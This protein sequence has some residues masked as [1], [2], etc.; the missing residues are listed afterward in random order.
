MRIASVVG[1]LAVTAVV[2]VL[3]LPSRL[4]TAADDREVKALEQ[5]YQSEIRRLVQR[6]CHEC[7]SEKRTEA[8]IDFTAFATWADVRKHPQTW[9]KALAMLDSGQMPPKK[10]RQPADA[11]RT[12]L[13][14]WVSG[15]LTVEAKARAGDPGRVMLRR[16]S[17]AEYTYTLR[18]LTGIDSLDPAREFPGDGAAGE[19]FTNTG[20]ALVMSPALLTKYLDAAKE[21][22]SHAVL[23]PDGFRFSP[24]TTPRDWTEETLAQIREFYREFSDPRGGDKVNLQG[25][26][27][28]TNQGGRL[29]L[30]RYF[31]ATIG[32]R[33]SLMMGRKSIGTVARKHG[34]NAR[35]LGTLWQSL[36]SHE[37]SLL[38]DGLRSR[39]RAARPE[40]AA[41]LG[42]DVAAWQKG[43][44]R[45]TTVGHIGK[46]GGPKKWLEPVTPLI[47][48]QEM[49]FK[50]PPSSDGEQVTLS[51]VASD[52]GDGNEHDFV[53]WQQP[54][55]MAPGRPDLLLR[56]VR[57]V[58][59]DLAAR[60]K[61][62]FAAAARYL[63]AAALAAAAPGTADVEQLARKHGV[64][65]DAL[66]AWLDYLGIGSGGSVALGGHFTNK[67]KSASGYDFIKG[68]GRNETPML[69]AN[70]SDKGVRIPGNM[71]PHSV[72]VHPSP[73]LRA[74]VGWRSPVTATFRVDA[75]V[76][77]AHPECGNG[78]TWSLELRRGAT[79]QRLAS[80]IAQGSKEGKADR[81]ERLAIQTGDLVSLLIGP[82][83]GNH[84]CDLTAIELKLSSDGGRTWDLAADVSSDVLAGNPHADRFGNQG[85]W[86]FYTEPD[87]GGSETGPVIPAGS[88]LAKWQLAR[89]ADEKR[90]L[91][92]DVQKLLTAGPPVV[93]GNPDLALY[94]QL[95]SLGGPLFGTMPRVRGGETTENAPRAN[96]ERQDP[97]MD[98]A[99]WG[100][101]PGM[102]AKHPSG[103]AIDAASLC[104]QA[105][106]V[107]TV[108]LP[109]E[110]ASGC[111]LVT[112]GV[113][114]Q[115]AG[116]LGSVQLELVAGRPSRESGL[117]PSEA[118]VTVANGQWTA[119]NQ[120]TSYATPI[121]VNENS[122]TRK[123]IESAFDDFRRLFPAALCYT[124]IVPVDEV[125]TLTLYYREDDHLARLMLDQSQQS[126]LN[127]LWD[128]L[129]YISQDALTQVDAFAQLME[130]ATQDADPKVF[131]PMRK[132][133]NDRATAFRQHLIDTQP[134]H[135]DVLLDFA[136][137]A[138]RRPL[139]VAESQ[140]L[141]ALYSKMRKQGIPHD[142]AFRLVLARVLVAPAFLY[143]VEKP[144]PGAGQGPVSDWEL[145]SRLSY[146]LWSTQ[147]DEELRQV[148]AAGRLRDPDTLVIEMR[149][150]LRDPRT[151][152]LATEFAC[153]W[154]HIVD[155]DHLDE[156]S[157]RHFPTFAGL[158]GAMY[159][160]SIQFFTDLFQN[161]GSVL[162]I[163]NA[164]Y[165][166]LNEPLAKHYGIPL[167]ESSQPAGQ[168]GSAD[169]RSGWR[170]V[171]G[172][173]QYGRGGILGQA[174]TLAKQSGA[175]RTSPILRGN[176]ISEVLLGERLPRPPKG[177]PLL[178]EDEAAT[179]GLTVR[180][181]VERHSSDAKCA[182]CHRRIDPL[183]FSLEGFDAIGRRRDKDLGGRP[184]DTRVKAMDG[185]QFDG[186]DGL[187]MY[188]LTARG[189]AFL[190][191][192]CRKLLG[193]A[194]GRSVQ[195]S[196]EPLLALMQSELKAKN[197][198]FVSAVEA[199]IRSR[200]FREI[201]GRETAH[202]E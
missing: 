186:L 71:K 31:A 6:Y 37:P 69:L 54:R 14:Q 24:H 115:A 44:W 99:D 42:A 67:L 149:R 191:Q 131:E 38:L 181:L 28:D 74:A 171:G 180:Q 80:G 111:E 173:K 177:V 96:A 112:T 128:E 148:A 45:F 7:H 198:H 75:T 130:Y 29:P 68:W 120:R 168:S 122:P 202:D 152:R 2:S 127:R 55:L 83:D 18:D 182:V 3:L 48:K 26:V 64:E 200:Q 162:D 143:R 85:I 40:D 184:I 5:A 82:R 57:E 81:I 114:D 16:L 144:G 73:T 170:R 63:N 56:D 133:I 70:A 174:T 137:R 194:L 165:T 9:Q 179:E 121:I 172:I 197:H 161:D 178:P 124:K 11:E 33:E 176:W 34:L 147:P 142:E 79:R 187:R 52:A 87:K 13:Q 12:R 94:R 155:F 108:R 185:A 190:R 139:T 158:K 105:P 72:A 36:V 77:H 167:K 88:L 189:E 59:R 104:V 136:G 76:T 183:G 50:I 140:D 47:A 141:R 62:V 60:R 49:R 164:D 21:V 10:A 192:F 101:D 132:P 4:A 163:L 39:W 156:K 123:R 91:A 20:N 97:A 58:F 199:I 154:L 138:Y 175:S 23:L 107:I 103:G 113:L 116:A 106:S 95:A 196:D 118:M 201:R 117:L 159:E 8:D 145:A 134:K 126:R 157:E 65:S 30:E 102:F 61:R 51:L 153:Q 17:N 146:F 93:K 129:H 32:E 41:A 22:A 19:G 90:K 66:L 188:L 135:L 27:F 110:L 53:V 84:A 169:A 86:H 166:F 78:V 100:L 109:A 151:R 15:Y 25:I 35:Y 92:G 43:L 150:M 125:V 195:F 119:N 160:E 89:D 1:V 193:Y 46:V 98:K